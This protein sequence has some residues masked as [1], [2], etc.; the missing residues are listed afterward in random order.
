MNKFLRKTLFGSAL[1]AALVIMG[2][3]SEET[4]T[5]STTAEEDPAANYPSGPITVV[6]PAGPGGDTDLNTRIMAKYL[7]DELDTN[8]VVSNVAGA[9]GATGSQSVN[10]AQANGQTVLAFHNSLMLNKIFGLTDYSYSDFKMAGIGVL[11]QSNTFL[12]SPESEFDDIESLIVYAKANPGKVTVATEVGSMTY[13]QTLQF[14][15]LAGVE[16][17]IVDIGGASDKIA[18]ILGGRVDIVPTSL[19]LVSS[20]IESGD[21]ISLGIMAEERLEGA[22]DVATF[23]EQGI[24]IVIDKVFYWAFHKDTPDEFVE[25]F[26]NAMKNVVANEEYQQEIKDSWLSPTFLNTEETNAKLEEINASYQ[27]AFN[28]TK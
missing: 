27:E 23:K 8:V 20:Y 9:G 22:P 21:M 10:S 15:E 7:K 4:V 24:D 12:T 13:I 18:A 14:Q 26:S 6:V 28:S 11:D 17:N 5:T 1:V 16:F 19:G 2:A 3:C 25:K